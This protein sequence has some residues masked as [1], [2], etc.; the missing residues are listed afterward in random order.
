MSLIALE[1]K[2]KMKVLSANPLFLAEKSHLQRHVPVAL[3]L[4]WISETIVILCMHSVV[5]IFLNLFFNWRKIA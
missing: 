4:L 3:F 5:I 1:W 2:N